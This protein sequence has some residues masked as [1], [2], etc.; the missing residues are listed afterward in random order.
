MGLDGMPILSGGE[1][2][3]TTP[4]SA[5]T[6]F[7]CTDMGKLNPPPLFIDGAEAGLPGTLLARHGDFLRGK[8]YQRYTGEYKLI[9]LS[10]STYG[11]KMLDETYKD[12]K[13]LSAN[14]L[15][16]FSDKITPPS[17]S[18]KT[19]PAVWKQAAMS[20]EDQSEW[21]R[22]IGKQSITQTYF[23]GGGM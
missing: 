8:G 11:M 15:I 1:A 4:P 6:T 18:M 17:K 14:P 19:R 20:K 2:R 21:K 5:H 3:V 13:V 10:D 7:Q 23:T 16:G 9:D 22:L 12:N